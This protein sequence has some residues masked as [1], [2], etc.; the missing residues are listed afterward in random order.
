MILALRDK[1]GDGSSEIDIAVPP[2]IQWA[3]LRRFGRT[4]QV[5]LQHYET[6]VCELEGVAQAAPLCGTIRMRLCRRSW[7]VLRKQQFPLKR[8]T[9][10]GGEVIRWLG[11]LFFGFK[12]HVQP[13]DSE[14]DQS[15]MS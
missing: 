2:E 15:S 5:L 9:R 7:I 6:S 3:I 10:E 14:F 1:L 13:S 4:P 8:R 12:F 11:F